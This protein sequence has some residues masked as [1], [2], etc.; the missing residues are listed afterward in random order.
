MVRSNYFSTG[1][2]R[3][4]RWR[5]LW[6]ASLRVEYLP[7]VNIK[8]VKNR[9]SKAP[10]DPE[11]GALNDYDGLLYGILETL[12]YGVKVPDL[13]ADRDWL[14]ELALQT[15]KTRSVAVGGVLKAYL[16][17]NEPED[18]LTEEESLDPAPEDALLL[19]FDWF[20]Q[21]RRYAKVDPQAP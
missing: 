12:K 11:I 14:I 13:I 6:Q 7:V 17:D 20:Q 2:V 19:Y 10:V 21:I 18:L 9:P 3:Q 15:H 16:R 5:E 8:T 1:Y 4:E